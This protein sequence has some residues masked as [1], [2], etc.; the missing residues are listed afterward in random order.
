M[1]ASKI[2]FKIRVAPVQ[3]KEA[4]A[5]PHL[6]PRQLVLHNAQLKAE[7]VA[8]QFLK[9]WVLGADTLVVYRQRIYGKPKNMRH[10]ERMLEQL[11]GRTHH[12]MTGVY[13]YH[14][15]RKPRRFCVTTKV[16]FKKL[17]R[18]EIRKYLQ[19]IHPLDKAGAY[20]A[21]EETDRIIHSVRGSFSNVVGLPMERLIQE[22]ASISKEA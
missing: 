7:A 11:V 21:Q 8:S 10:A 4:H 16:R 12:V 17:A 5:A 19:I 20:A 22:L 14:P 3:E 2:P 13:L 15:Q 1:K 9:S 18:A 6:S